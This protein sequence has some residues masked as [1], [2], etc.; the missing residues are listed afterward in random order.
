MRALIGSWPAPLRE[1]Y[2]LPVTAQGHWRELSKP[3]AA[4]SQLSSQLRGLLFLEFPFLWTK[5]FE[6]ENNINDGTLKGVAGI[7]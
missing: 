4:Q 3:N 5:D 1:P 6:I 2:T 7:F